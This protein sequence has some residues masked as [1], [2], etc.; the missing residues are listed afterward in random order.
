M[1]SYQKFPNTPVDPATISLGVYESSIIAIF[2]IVLG[3]LIDVIF[4]KINKPNDKDPSPVFMGMRC[5]G[6]RGHEF[7]GQQFDSVN[8]QYQNN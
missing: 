4:K 5:Q 6:N 2:A 7:Y 8:K 1:E 3:T